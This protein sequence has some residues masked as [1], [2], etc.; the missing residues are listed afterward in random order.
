MNASLLETMLVAVLVGGSLVFTVWRLLP[1]AWR[2]RLQVRL[3]WRVGAAACGCDACPGT[4]SRE[5]G[6]S[7][8]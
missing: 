7:A 2:T 6:R 8:S 3:G 5:S 4:S 1:V